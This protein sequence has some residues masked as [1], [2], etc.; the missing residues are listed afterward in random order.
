M[1]KAAAETSPTASPFYGRLTERGRILDLNAEG[2]I[3]WSCSPIR[4]DAGNVHVFFTRV[5]VGSDG[6]F[7]NFR[8]KAEIV[9]AVADHPE[10]PYEVQEVVLKGRGEGCWDAFGVVNPRIYRVDGQYALLYTAYEIPRPRETIREHIGLL[11]SDDLKTWR[12]GN[13]GKPIL[14]PSSNPEDWDSQLINNA[15][16][17]KEPDTGNYRLYYRGVKNLTTNPRDSIG[18]AMARSI[19]GPWVKYERNP[20]IS[21]DVLRSPDVDKYRGLEDPCVWYEDGTFR[22]LT[23][24]MGYFKNPSSLYIESEDGLDWGPPV[25]GYKTRDDSPQILFDAEGKP[26]YLFVNRHRTKPLT[27]FVFKIDQK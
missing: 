15:S 17:V 27:G 23:K 2:Y 18:V 26:E 22:M 8:L 24:D 7:K 12:R 3:V 4:D 9:H 20:V 5:P 19:E 11:L 13:E 14:S 6:W 21:P 16:L 1:S 10:G 25:R